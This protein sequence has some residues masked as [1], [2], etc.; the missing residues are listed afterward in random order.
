VLAVVVWSWVVAVCTLSNLYLNMFRTSLCTSSGEQDRVLLHMVYSAGCVGCGCV[1]L[2][3]SCVHI[4][5][6]V[7][8]HVSDIIMPIISRTR[9]C[10]T[11]YGVLHWLCWLWLCGA[12]S[13]AVCTDDG[14]ND[15]RN[16]L[17]QKFDNKHRISCI[18]L[19]YL[20]SPY[21]ATNCNI[22]VFMTVCIYRYIHTTQFCVTDLTQRR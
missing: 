18:L 14:H 13:Q 16:K 17:R 2:G 21:I 19:V 3:R 9:P 6:L 4:I 1:E 7:S 15:A 20:S 5:K 22:V 10:I 8:Q 11:A 12:E